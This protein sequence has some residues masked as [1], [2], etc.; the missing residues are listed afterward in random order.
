MDEWLKGVVDWL[1]SLPIHQQVADREWIVPAVQTIHI[2]CVAIVM[3][4]ALI[5][6]LRGVGL[7]GTHWSLARWHQRFRGSTM[8]ALL[9]LLATGCVMIL[10]EPE[11]ELMNWIFRAKMVLVIVTILIW[12]VLGGRLAQAR[13]DRPATGGTRLL[14][15]V[16]LFAWIG[17]AA[18]GRWIAYAG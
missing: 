7:T 13:A 8:L 10:A 17:A 16:V 14:A 3:S 2:I 18:A 11:R 5:I 12:R 4:S 15:F 1:I 6:A 9:G